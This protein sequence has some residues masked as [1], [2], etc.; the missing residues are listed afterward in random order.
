MSRRLQLILI[1]AASMVAIGAASST[2]NAQ[3]KI[4]CANEA[5]TKYKRTSSAP[6][7]CVRFGPN[8]SFGG[9]VFLTNLVW[10]DFG[11]PNP[12]ATGIECGF[13]LPCANIPVDVTAYRPRKD[14]GSKVYTRLRA[15]STFGTTTVKMKAC[16]GRV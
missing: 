9:G 4:N 14:C 16:P 1:G 15:T 7:E 8:G 6:T 13:H 11:A 5:G 3:V 2:A 12:T 10:T